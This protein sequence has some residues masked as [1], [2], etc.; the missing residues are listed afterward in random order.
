M[1]KSSKLD[2]QRAIT[3]E[4]LMI[5][6]SFSCKNKHYIVVVL[7]PNFHLSARPSSFFLASF[8]HVYEEIFLETPYTDLVYSVDR[9]K[10]NGLTL[11]WPQK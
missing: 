1:S 11:I 5:Q 7:V 10:V 9:K 6:K 2:I 3:A 4:K 8:S